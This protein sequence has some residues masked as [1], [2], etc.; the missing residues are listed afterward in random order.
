MAYLTSAVKRANNV[1]LITLFDMHVAKSLVR[2]NL[3][4][5]IGPITRFGRMNQ[6]L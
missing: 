6:F 4:A 1:V 2:L 5:C 3:H